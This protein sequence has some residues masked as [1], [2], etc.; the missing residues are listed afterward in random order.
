MKTSTLLTS[1]GFVLALAACSTA[2]SETVNGG[3]GEGQSYRIT[4]GG[5]FSSASECFERAGFICGNRGYTVVRE[6]DIAPPEGSIFFAPSAH[7]AIVRCNSSLGG[8]GSGM[9]VAP[10][11]GVTRVPN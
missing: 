10:V 6:T 3:D 5:T 1:L 4:C 9:G 8:M 11:G 2:P 7:E